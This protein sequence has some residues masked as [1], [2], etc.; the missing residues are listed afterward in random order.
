MTLVASALCALSHGAVEKI[1]AILDSKGK[2]QQKVLCMKLSSVLQDYSWVILICIFLLQCTET[3]DN[4]T[5][6]SRAAFVEFR[7]SF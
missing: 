3:E 1:R 7:E 6:R 2:G 5:L 4:N